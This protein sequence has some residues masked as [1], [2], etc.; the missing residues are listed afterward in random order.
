M[1]IL[2]TLITRMLLKGSWVYWR[3]V[4]L[5]PCFLSLARSKLRLCLVNHRAVTCD[6]LSLVWTYSEQEAENG[7]RS[8]SCVFESVLHYHDLHLCLVRVS[9]IYSSAGSSAS[10]NGILQNG[11]NDSFQLYKSSMSH[12]IGMISE[13]A[14]SFRDVY[15]LS[16]EH[17]SE[18]QYHFS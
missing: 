2:K 10:I 1:H 13:V 8:A 16:C 14:T 7:P 17:Y 15:W 5:L 12:F 11:M 9:P 18:Q 4:Q 3:R 6:W